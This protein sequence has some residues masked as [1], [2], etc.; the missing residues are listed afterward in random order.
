MDYDA[1]IHDLRSSAKAFRENTVYDSEGDPVR[2]IVQADE[3]DKAAAAIADLRERNE[4]LVE[5]LEPFVTGYS[6]TSVFLRSRQ[7][8]H[9]AGQDLYRDDV[10]R[11]IAALKEPS[12]ED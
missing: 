3:A 10:E 9:P 8:M 6:H 1:L 7:K 12:H 11:A 5:A 4:A 2:L